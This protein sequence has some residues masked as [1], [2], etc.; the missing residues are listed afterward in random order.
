MTVLA[1]VTYLAVQYCA[2]RRKRMLE[3]SRIN[4]SQAATIEIGGKFDKPKDAESERKKLNK[5]ADEDGFMDMAS[6]DHTLNPDK[7]D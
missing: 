7:Q 6:G 3:N 5:D 1:V 2:K 4:A